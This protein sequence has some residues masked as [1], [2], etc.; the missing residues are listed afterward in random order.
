MGGRGGEEMNQFFLDVGP[1][2][3]RLHAWE[4]INEMGL[5]DVVELT[6]RQDWISGRSARELR[7]TRTHGREYYFTLSAEL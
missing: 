4:G 6:Q 1:A 2:P 3:E 7:E 5:P